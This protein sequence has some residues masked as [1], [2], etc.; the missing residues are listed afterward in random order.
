MSLG[1]ATFSTATSAWLLSRMGTTSMPIPASASVRATVRAS[2][3]FSLPSVTITIRLADSSGNDAW[4]IFRAEP[5][6]VASV[7]NS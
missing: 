4:A 1:R 6:F 2:P 7:R 5:M 3:R